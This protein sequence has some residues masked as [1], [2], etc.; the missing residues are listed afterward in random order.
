MPAPFEGLLGNTCELRLVQFF[1]PVKE[2]EYNISEMAREIGMSRQAVEPVVK[3]LTKW[4]VLKVAQKHGNAYYYA[5]NEKSGFIEVFENLNNRIIE[6]MLGDE[7]L[8]Q[9]AQYSQDHSPRT[10][11]LSVNVQR[12]YFWEVN[13]DNPEKKLIQLNS[14]RLEWA[15]IFEKPA[16]IQN[17]VAIP[18]EKYASAAAA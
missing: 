14:A 7:I 2:L 17:A 4:G 18:G 12:C 8:E 11:P 5:L 10:I 3:K 6:R 13:P 15:T 16:H 1:L 9:V